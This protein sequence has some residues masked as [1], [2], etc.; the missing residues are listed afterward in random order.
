MLAAAL[1]AEVNHYMAELAA[2]TDETVR[3]LV[4]RNTGPAPAVTA[5]EPVAVKAPRVNN[6]GV[7]ETTGERQR[8]SSILPP[9]RRKSPKVSEM[10]PL[11]YLQ[12][13]SSGTSP[14]RWSSSC[15][16]AGLR[17]PP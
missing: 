13:L 10:P 3:R 8:F 1:E 6:R 5:A 2:E 16:T 15:P 4:V 17:R 9:W 12:E 14:R 11:P 7:D